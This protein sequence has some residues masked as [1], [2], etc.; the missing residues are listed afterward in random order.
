MSSAL[1]DRGSH[2]QLVIFASSACC[3]LTTRSAVACN[4]LRAHSHR[5][6]FCQPFVSSA[7]QQMYVSI[8]TTGNCDS[9]TGDGVCKHYTVPYPLCTRNIFSRVVQECF[10]MSSGVSFKKYS[11]L[12]RI[13]CH[14][15]SSCSDLPPFPLPQHS[16]SLLYPSH[17]DE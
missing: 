6:G 12:S 4:T 7:K 13:M 17:S 1:M 2:A 3:K 8:S 14:S 5:H 11:S 16:P 9:H 10:V 15:H